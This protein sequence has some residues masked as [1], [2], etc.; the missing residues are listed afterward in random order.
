MHIME[1][2]GRSRVKVKEEQ[3][4]EASEPMIEWCPLFDKIRGIKKDN[5]RVGRRKYGISHPEAW[6]VLAA[7]K[8][9]NGCFCRLRCLRVDDDGP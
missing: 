2:L 5:M 6:N 8:A 7:A 9:G 4:L 1:L 3:V